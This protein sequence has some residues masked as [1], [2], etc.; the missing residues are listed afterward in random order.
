M[1]I[2][3]MTKEGKINSSFLTRCRKTDLSFVENKQENRTL[4]GK[5][6]HINRA[7]LGVLK[8]VV[9]YEHIIYDFKNYIFQIK[10]FARKG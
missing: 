2:L 4:N 1:Q 3:K 7:Q 6:W 10:L 9:N 8:G 5:I